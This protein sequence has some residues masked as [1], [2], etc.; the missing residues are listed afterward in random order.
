MCIWG[1]FAIAAVFFGP[2]VW[3][4]IM[5]GNYY[6]CPDFWLLMLA[7]ALLWPLML[8]VWVYAYLEYKRRG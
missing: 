6:R 5:K 1:Y 2:S 4:A 8:P 7:V 3:L